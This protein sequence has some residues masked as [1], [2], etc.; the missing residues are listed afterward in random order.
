MRTQ[1]FIALE[2]EKQS[3][4]EKMFYQTGASLKR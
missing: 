3:H 2:E 1:E 4:N